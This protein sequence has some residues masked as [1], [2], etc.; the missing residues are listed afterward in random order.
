MVSLL[1]VTLLI[2]CISD[3]AKRGY[4]AIKT[5]P[6]I[7]TNLSLIK[8]RNIKHAVSLF[9]FGEENHSR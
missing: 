2:E 9:Y 5:S 4:L 3:G 7:H 6:L 8:N 1:Q